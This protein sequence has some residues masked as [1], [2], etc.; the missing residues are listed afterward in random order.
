VLNALSLTAVF[1]ALVWMFQD[2]HL[3]GLLDFTPTPTNVSM[4]VLI[5]CI[6]FGLSMDYEVFLLARIKEAHDDGADTTEAV[7]TGLA[8]TGRIVT[9][10][11]ALL[12]VTFFAFGTAQISFLQLFGIGTGIAIV[13]DATI[14]RGVLVP[15]FMRLAGH[16]NWWAPPALRRLHQRVGLA[17]TVTQAAH[18]EREPAVSGGR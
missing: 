13:L 18:E 14:V 2:G 6:A 3:A 8:R 4:I 12:A 16:L 11:A 5:F 15:A 7:A 1:G 10:A 17:E 9:T